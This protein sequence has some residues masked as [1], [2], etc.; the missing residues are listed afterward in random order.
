MF[1]FLTKTFLAVSLEII[2]EV[3]NT[4]QNSTSAATEAKTN[5][6]DIETH[7]E[8]HI[9]IQLSDAA[10]KDIRTL[11]TNIIKIVLFS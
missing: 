8:E 6:M 10:E 11:G 4:K 5:S 3:H 2:K 7:E 1:D 9:R